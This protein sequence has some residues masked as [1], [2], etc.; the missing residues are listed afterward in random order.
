MVRLLVGENAAIE[1]VPHI[2]RV[3]RPGA[4]CALDKRRWRHSH[5]AQERDDCRQNGEGELD[6]WDHSGYQPP[7][8]NSRSTFDMNEMTVDGNHS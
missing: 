3:I 5:R 7:L 4:R 1:R 6:G 2:D 8:S